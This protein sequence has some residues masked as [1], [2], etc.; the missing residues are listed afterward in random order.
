VISLGIFSAMTEPLWDS[1]RLLDDGNGFGAFLAGLVGY[2]ARP[3]LLPLLS[4]GFYWMIAS[5]A[6]APPL[7]GK[8]PA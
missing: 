8:A 6:Y 2:R 3:E 5:L 7:T 4:L 1:S